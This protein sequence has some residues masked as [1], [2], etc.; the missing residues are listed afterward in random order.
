MNITNAEFRRMTEKEGVWQG[1]VEAKTDL[2]DAPSVLVYF[3][4]NGP[5]SLAI[6]SIVANDADYETDWYDNP[7]HQAFVNETSAFDG[8]ARGRMEEMI[9]SF[10]SVREQLQAGFEGK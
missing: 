9:L 3:K 2:L 8:D 4:R 5:S 7:M 6:S 1:E 10:D